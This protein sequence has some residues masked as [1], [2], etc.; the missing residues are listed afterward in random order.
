MTYTSYTDSAQASEDYEDASPLDA[1]MRT[2]AVPLMVIFG[3]EDQIYD[4]DASLAA[5]ADVPGVRTAKVRGAGH[6]PNVEKPVQTAALISEFAADAGDDSIEHPPRTWGA[7]Q[8]AAARAERRCGGSERLASRRSHAHAASIAEPLERRAGRTDRRVG[9]ARAIPGLT[10]SLPARLPPVRPGSRR[11]ST[12]QK[13]S[14][15]RWSP[16]WRTR[17]TW[18]SPSSASQCE[19]RSTPASTRAAR[20][21]GPPPSAGRASPRGRRARAGRRSRAVLRPARRRESRRRRSTAAPHH[22]HVEL[23]RP[24][25]RSG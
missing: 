9:N 19:Q 7:S 25:R 10:P 6:S 12:E 14:P 16:R 20:P 24:W 13:P 1:R 3:A 23:L 21:A 22:E 17:S 2:T 5:Y 4:V 8:R 15:I 18:T 11:C